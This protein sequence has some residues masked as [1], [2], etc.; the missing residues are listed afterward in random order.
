[1][2]ANI[3]KYIFHLTAIIIILILGIGWLQSRRE[4]NALRT[5]VSIN[6]ADLSIGR[7]NT[8]TSNPNNEIKN[9]DKNIQDDIKKTNA[10]VEVIGKATAV[11]QTNGSGKVIVSGCTNPEANSKLEFHDFRLDFSGDINKQTA[12]YSLHQKFETQYAETKLPN[13]TYNS[14]LELYE[15]DNSGKRISKL[16]LT[17]FNAVHASLEEKN[18]FTFLNPRLDL[19]VGYMMYRNFVTTPEVSV[20]L[21]LSTYGKSSS[22]RFRFLRLDAGVNRQGVSVGL[23]PVMYNLAQPLPL[24]DNLWLT[25]KL[26]YTFDNK[27]FS[28]GIG[29]SVVL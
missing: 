18:H 22:L 9:L 8:T 16:E 21:S 1:M 12:K 17:K 6:T 3:K 10:T 20:G 4:N 7:A 15:L 19:G 14:Y 5:Q 13:G 24:I 25:P 11:S 26:S 2:L 28:F 27:S 23:S 29:I